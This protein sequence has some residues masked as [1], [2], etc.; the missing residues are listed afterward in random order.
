MENGFSPQPTCQDKSN[1]LLDRL[2]QPSLGKK[3]GI[4]FVLFLAL[5]AGNLIMVERLHDAVDNTTTLVNDSGR[6]LY[7]SQE[8]AFQSARLAY[9]KRQDGDSLGQLRAK[10]EEKLGKVELAARQLPPVVGAGSINLSSLLWDLKE[11][12]L[13]YRAVVDLIRNRPGEIDV[14]V[15]FSRLGLHSA[16]M[17]DM[18]DA[19]VNELERASSKAHAKVDSMLRA[20][21]A[22]EVAFVLVLFLYLRRKVFLP[23]REVSRLVSRFAAGDRSARIN[24]KSRDEIGELARNFNQTAE[25][26]GKLI[27]GLDIGLKV[28]AT[29]HRAARIL[30]DERRPAGEVMRELALILPAAFQNPENRVA[31]IVYEGETFVTP[32]FRETPS[33]LCADFARGGSSQASVEV[34]SLD[35]VAGEAAFLEEELALIRSMA[36]MLRSYLGRSRAQQ[37]RGRLVAI[38]EATPDF[39]STVTQDGKLLY[40]NRAGREM[41]GLGEEEDVTRYAISHCHPEWANTVIMNV[42]LPTAALEGI[43]KGETALLRRDGREIPTSEV[44]IAHKNEDGAVNFLSS[45]AR[46]ITDRIDLESRLT[47]SRDFYLGLFQSFPNLIWRSGTDGQCD[48]FNKTWLDFTGRK[49]EQ[50]LGGGWEEGVHPEDRA[51]C[52]KSYREAFNEHQA[53][54]IEYRLR[55]HDGEYRWIIDNGVPFEDL[56]GDFAGYI[57]VCY[58][59][60]ERKSYES[61]LQHQANYDA[62]TELPNR[63]LSRDRLD[64]A[65][66]YARRHGRDLALMFI[67]LDHFKNINDS[68]GHNIGDMLLRQVSA[69]LTGCVREGDTVARQGGDEFVVILA[70]VATEEDVTAVTRKILRAMADSYAIDGHELYVTCSIGIAMFP[71]DGEDSQTLLKNADTALYRAKD[72]G[73]NNSQF[74]AAEMNLKALERL[75]MENGLRHALER[76]EF[77]VHYQPR[78]DLRSGEIVGT[79]ALVRWQHPELGLTPPARFIPVAEESGLILPLGEWVL[80]AAC[81]QNKAW[82]HAGLK[83]LSI[84]VNLS[85]YQFRQPGLVELVTRVL[86]ETDLDPAFLELELTESAI[87]QNVEEIIDTLTRL[88]AMGVK[89]SVDDFG[90]GFSSLSYLKRFPIDT[91]KIDQSFVRDITTDPDDAA[92]AKTIISMAHD[93]QLRVIAE[94]VETEE[95]KSFLRL[96]H[97]DEMQGFFFSRPVPAEEIEVMLGERR[98]LPMEDAAAA[99]LPRTLLL[100]DDEENILTSLNR[101][102]RRDGYHILKATSAAEAFELLAEH[103]VGVIVSDQRMP[104]MNGTEFLRRVKQIYPDTVRMVL[105]GYTDLKSVTDAIN[106]GAVYRFLTK[107]WDDDLL[108]ASIQEAFQRYELA[109]DNQRLSEEMA[110]INEELYRAKHELEKRVEQKTGEVRQNIGVLQVSQEMLEYLPVG[111]IGV[112]ED[113]L[114]AVA[115]RK[116]NELFDAGNKSSLVGSFAQERLPAAMIE[117]LSGACERRTQR[118]E[119]GRNVIFWSHAMGASSG[120]EGRMLVIVPNEESGD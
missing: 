37:S 46:D 51:A 33:R 80:R 109:Q 41:L 69:R 47:Q 95:Q 10:F 75:Q 64:Q 1:T 13:G 72:L 77:V 61:Q 55:R 113:G 21:L 38:L 58:D 48:Y 59:V 14:A 31:R 9:E 35:E 87:M 40:V 44:I 120:S 60:T 70:D 117:C 16:A 91:L 62:L 52:L 43:W 110:L 20:I 11:A 102:L 18:A 97:C 114:I 90:T 49:L 27:D 111:V 104:E 39:V 57:G 50:E 28:N 56:N 5:T 6:L 36:E 76:N 84:S 94:G 63:N 29:L 25:T 65:I 83:P 74:Y 85:A 17:L 99:L 3:L 100:L 106:E 34:F 79:E 98:R 30:Q 71:K 82:Q 118:L 103:P 4:A 107:P 78:V 93:L 73:R 108:R 116:A 86:K 22:M 8:I 24:F 2:M 105:S 119:N 67:D 54:E 68:L 92:I 15:A 12:W 112:G 19:V 88:K 32:G 45:I 89:F 26:V 115:N 81:A 96:R 42:G 101:L 53:F 7:L 66:S 23:V